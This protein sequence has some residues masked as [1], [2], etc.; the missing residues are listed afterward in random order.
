MYFSFSLFI[1]RISVLFDVQLLWFR[2]NID[3]MFDVFSIMVLFFIIVL[4]M[5]IFWD[6]LMIFLEFEFIDIVWFI[7]D[8]NDFV[9]ELDVVIFMFVLLSEVMY[10]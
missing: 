10:I 4:F 8:F 7:L 3:V 2:V 6:I 1:G 5:W 9:N